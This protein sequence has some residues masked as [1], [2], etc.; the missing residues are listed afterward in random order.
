LL[1]L[2]TD[3][4]LRLKVADYQ[5]D[6]LEE[7]LKVLGLEG[8]EIR[9]VTMNWAENVLRFLT[10][11][12][13]SSLLITLAMVGILIELRTPGFGFPGVIGV[14]SLGLFL[15]GHWIVKLAGW[16]ELLIAAIGAVLLVVD[17]IFIAGFGLAGFTGILAIFAGLVMSM[18]GPGDTPQF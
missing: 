16:E 5:A 2:T 6:T 8:A 15:W 12:V 1:T 13:V 7:V 14:S 10:H 11:P 9:P 3:E 17:L 4:S 18:V